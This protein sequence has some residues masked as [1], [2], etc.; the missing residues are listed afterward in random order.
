[1]ENDMKKIASRNHKALTLNK[2]TIRRLNV[3]QLSQA[4]GGKPKQTSGGGGGGGGGGTSGEATLDCTPS[5]T[6]SI[7]CF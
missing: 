3:T 5:C 1:M 2:D 6:N 4:A 7:D